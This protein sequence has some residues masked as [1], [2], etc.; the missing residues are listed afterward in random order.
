MSQS[1]IYSESKLTWWW[2]RERKLPD[3]PKQ[4]QLILSD[5]CNQGCSF[6]AYRMDGYTSNELFVGNSPVDPNHRN[7]PIRW[8]PTE[9]ALRL[10]D[11]FK[12]AGVL[13]VQFTG[14]GE[15]TV[16]PDHE[17]IFQKT[18]DLGLRASLVSNGV[19]WSHRL[20]M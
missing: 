1:G 16:H 2:A 18:L 15:P 5:L 20:I 9:R 10:I 14:G 3:A 8:I 12:E 19:K 13:A 11:E 6:C 4:V 7:N 17:A